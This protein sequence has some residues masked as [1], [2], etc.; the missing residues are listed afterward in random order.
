MLFQINSTSTISEQ[1]KRKSDNASNRNEI[2][3]CK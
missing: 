2:A 3:K 1:H